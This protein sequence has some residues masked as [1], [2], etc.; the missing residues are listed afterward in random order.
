MRLGEEGNV[1][2]ELLSIDRL[3]CRIITTT[4]TTHYI[5]TILHT[6]FAIE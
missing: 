6:P 3:F 2:R 5:G 4:T 1:L